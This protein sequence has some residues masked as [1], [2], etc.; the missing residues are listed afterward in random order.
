M[1]REQIVD[2]TYRVAHGLNE[3][4][5]ARKLIDEATYQVVDGHLRRAQE[6]VTLID[7]ALELSPELRATALTAIRLRV[8]EANEASLCATDELK[9]GGAHVGRLAPRPSL[10]Y[11][12]GLGRS[13]PRSVNSRHR[14]TGTYD[15]AYSAGASCRSRPGLGAQ[16]PKLSCSACRNAP[17]GH[18]Q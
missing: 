4:K 5:H 13:V 11:R 7:Q 15:T 14:L 1:T 6:T 2:T 3:L 8:S 9:W 17:A 10:A 12:L 18:R 16:P